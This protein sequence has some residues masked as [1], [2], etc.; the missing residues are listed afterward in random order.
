MQK[1]ILNL[2]IVA[3]LGLLSP[4]CSQKTSSTQQANTTEQARPQRGGE[5]PSGERPQFSDLLTKM[6]SNKDGKLAQSEVQ[7]PLKD[8]FSNI[9]ANNDGFITQAEFENAPQPP[10]R[11]RN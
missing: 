8:G 7:G 3:I 6:D 4:A 9:D 1:I 5:R 10:R 11:G 2:L